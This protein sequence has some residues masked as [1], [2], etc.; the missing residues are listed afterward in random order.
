MDQERFQKACDQVMHEGRERDGI[1]TLSEKTLHAVLKKYYEPDSGC[2]EI[3]VGGF[4]A[5]IVGENGI[6]EIQTR[7]FDKLRRKLSRFL[8]VSAVTV[9]YPCPRTKWLI[10]VDPETRAV[11]KKRKSPKQGTPA[12]AFYELYK[13]KNL[14]SHPN[15]RLSIVLMDL[16]EYRY[17]DGWSVDKKKGSSRCERIPLELVEEISIACPLDYEKLLPDALPCPFTS[18]DFMTAAKLSRSAAQ[19]ALNTLHSVGAVLRVGKKGNLY[20]YE[21]AGA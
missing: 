17:L 19:T 15:L 12:Q 5:D 4:V 2:H 13:I 3:K 16:E 6:I 9:V 1:G 7:N 8:E 21:R 10:W 14:L 20:L 18:R 11:T